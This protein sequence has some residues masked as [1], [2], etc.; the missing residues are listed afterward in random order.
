MSASGASSSLGIER[1]LCELHKEDFIPAVWLAF[2]NRDINALSTLINALH[3]AY[4]VMRVVYQLLEKLI[5]VADIDFLNKM[6][7]ECP[8]PIIKRTASLL[9]RSKGL[10]SN[11]NSLNCIK[12]LLQMSL[13]DDERFD[14]L[15]GEVMRENINAIRLLLPMVEFTNKRLIVFLKFIH[16]ATHSKEIIHV[17]RDFFKHKL[18]EIIDEK[19]SS[20]NTA[21][22]VTQFSQLIFY[23]RQ[24]PSTYLD[25][26]LNMVNHS[27]IG[28]NDRYCTDKID[29]EKGRP[30]VLEIKHRKLPI[31]YKIRLPAR[32]LKAVIID[33][34]GGL[35]K[36]QLDDYTQALKNYRD[37]T[38]E[39]IPRLDNKLINEGIAI[40]DTN[41]CDLI[42]LNVGQSQMSESL[43][44]KIHQSINCLYEILQDHPESLHPKLHKLKNLPFFLRGCSFGGLMSARYAQLAGQ[45]PNHFRRFNGYLSFN[46]GLSG[47]MLFKSDLPYLGEESE[48]RDYRAYFL[49]PY[50]YI[51]FIKDPIL[52][53]VCLDDNNVNAKVS[54][55]FVQKAHQHEKGHLVRLH[56]S[57]NGNIMIKL[58]VPNLI[59]RPATKG[60][61]SIDRNEVEAYGDA[62]LDFIKNPISIMP[63][64]SAW[65]EFYNNHNTNEF[66]RLAS[67]EDRF[68]A[69][70]L[71]R[72]NMQSTSK[73]LSEIQN[74]DIWNC[75]YI[76][77]YL[78]Y[79]YA[80]QTDQTLDLNDSDLTD[81]VIIK[82]FYDKADVFLAYIF[83]AYDI[84]GIKSHDIDV[85]EF[86]RL[87]VV[88][89]AFRESIKQI[90]NHFNFVSARF[91]LEQL[92]IHNPH[93]LP[94]PSAASSSASSALPG[95]VIARAKLENALR[96]NRDHILSL[97]RKSVQLSKSPPREVMS[98]KHMLGSRLS[99]EREC[100]R[101]CRLR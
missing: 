8:K 88:I 43:F 85:D 27:L 97:W 70:I 72:R 3:P 28:N 37:E 61:M 78:A 84:K 35:S 96:E 68:V 52:V 42:E 69:H 82:T 87:P 23:P 18:I 33:I 53:A 67:P 19:L 80:Y 79:H 57:Q 66:Y 40:V 71:K 77:I 64:I 59:C 13:T 38:L 5:E 34:Y 54:L 93:L 16:S 73:L 49:N 74:D 15:K 14:K 1:S 48:R 81:E 24:D 100:K 26:Y 56:V 12:P 4:S 63:E 29:H 21:D 6:L 94:R 51:E 46:G 86:I 20:L 39:L 76:Q 95:S 31:G 91:L 47:E 45:Y 92:Y 10:P 17:A 32:E 25:K 2:D 55:D 60:H 36:K 90:N 7:D 65:R 75:H 101:K 30:L 11:E 9:M 89:S 22:L 83:E 41:L 50:N 44:R 62:V 58:D 98:R 99:S